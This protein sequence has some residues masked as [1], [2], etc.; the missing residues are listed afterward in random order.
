VVPRILLSSAN[1]GLGDSLCEIV[2][3]RA[4]RRANL[5]AEIGWVSTH[6][7]VAPEWVTVVDRVKPPV[8]WPGYVEKYRAD[9]PDIRDTTLWDMR[10]WPLQFNRWAEFG[11]CSMPECYC[12]LVN[13]PFDP[14]DCLDVLDLLPGPGHFAS[15]FREAAKAVSAIGPYCVIQGGP[16]IACPRK[17]QIEDRGEV[18]GY[19]RSKGYEVVALAG[20]DANAC[21]PNARMVKGLSYRAAALVIH[22]A[23]RYVGSDTGVTW[24]A[25][26]GTRTPVVALVRPEMGRAG[27]VLLRPDVRE[28][29]N[30][31]PVDDVVDLVR[32]SLD[33]P[34]QVFTVDAE[35]RSADRTPVERMGLRDAPRA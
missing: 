9:W 5:Y 8:D 20:N 22:W 27:S 18:A 1:N 2:A 21:I 3:L 15:A 28:I 30:D 29:R 35:S 34:T 25:V 14:V 6:P 19:L 33:E 13:A 24:L 12:R 32:R 16:N 7:E 17:W 26:L 4:L 10:G 31:T 11:W 23:V